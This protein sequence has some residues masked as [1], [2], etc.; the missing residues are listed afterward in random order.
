MLIHEMVLEW[1]RW[2]NT[3]IPVCQLTTA[4]VDSGWHTGE[5]EGEREEEGAVGNI[6]EKLFQVSLSVHVR[7]LS[8][9]ILCLQACSPSL[10]SSYTYIQKELAYNNYYAPHTL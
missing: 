9:H 2:G 8:V 4:S 1:V 5:E 7:E 10:Y 3:E 6:L